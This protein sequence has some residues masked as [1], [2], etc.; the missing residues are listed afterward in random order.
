MFNV[1]NFEILQIAESVARDEGISRED[2]LSAM[3]AAVEAAGRNK[4]GSE[5]NIR[6]RIS[7]KNGEIT[8]FKILEV[9]E[10]PFDLLT[11]I[12]LSDALRLDPTL[13]IG[14]EIVE[15]L[16][17]IDLVRVAA[18]NAKDV[19]ISRVNYAR[20]QKQYEE[21]K[22]RAG[23]IVTCIIK[24]VEFG[25]VY[26]EVG[27]VE[28]VI[29]HD[30]LIPNESFRVND[31][32]RA[33]IMH[34]NDDFTKPLL[35]LSRV[36]NEFLVKL[37]ES[38]VPE[39][40]E[41]RIEI[42]AVA[43]DPGS[44]AKVAVFANEFG[45]DAVGACVGIRGG[46]VRAITQELAGE[47]I[48]IVPWNKDLAQFIVSAMAP[49]EITKV[50]INEARHYA[51]VIVVDDKLSMAIGKKGQ[52][53]KLAVK[54]TGWG[55]NV[56]TEEKESKRRVEEFNNATRALMESLEVE[57]VLAQLL[58][59][60]GLSTVEQIAFMNVDTLAAL[61]GFDLELANTLKARAEECLMR[62]NDDIL[63]ELEEL[64]VE[65]ELL[66]ILD[67]P[68]EYIL[69]LAEEGVKSLEDFG[70]LSVREFKQIIP[71]LGASD[72]DIQT[73]LDTLVQINKSKVSE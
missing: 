38:E 47:K 23:E 69:L 66:D 59:A 19:L 52:N 65:Q 44:K 11:Q 25:N 68:L 64:G 6:A 40:V 21:L 41:K 48:D 36:H 22:N 37:F 53:V 39:I 10:E 18:K 62:H 73:M 61:E 56:T 7:R 70:E 30:Q 72:E 33:Y 12:S 63:L 51:D 16:P 4:Y 5:H 42:R 29:H 71:D 45:L 34:V 9:V 54:L 67:L 14:S 32:V 46:R 26:V 2:V 15:Q 27:R 50:V 58:V 8:L 28:A 24:R 3:E 55:I 1:S 20:R 60:E 35:M 31:R 57:E 17:P 43:R 13:E 49:A